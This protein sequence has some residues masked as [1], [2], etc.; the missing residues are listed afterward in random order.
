MHIIHDIIQQRP[1]DKP[2]IIAVLN[3]HRADNEK[4]EANDLDADLFVLKFLLAPPP[5]EKLNQT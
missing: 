5:K 3:K 2:K 4:L 1:Q